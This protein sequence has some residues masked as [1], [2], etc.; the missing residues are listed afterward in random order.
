MHNVFYASGFLYHPPSQQILLQ[1]F[2][3]DTNHPAV[4][5]V[6]SEKGV[7]NETPE[8][9]FHRMVTESLGVKV[10]KKSCYFIYDYVH[11]DLKVPHFTHYAV[12]NKLYEEDDLLTENKTAWFPFKQLIKLPMSPQARQECTVGQRVINLATRELNPTG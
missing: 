3:T 5:T 6:F 4:W 10:T 2:T 7:E 11:K 1:Q 12:V 8:S 9:A